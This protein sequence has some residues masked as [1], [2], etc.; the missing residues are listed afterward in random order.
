[1]P[2]C[3]PW[4]QPVN[5]RGMNALLG[6]RW[7]SWPRLLVIALTAGAL[8]FVFSR[9]ELGALRE[10]LART[11]PGWLLLAFTCYG[12]ALVFG[13]IRWHVTLHAIHCAVH[14]FAAI[15]LTFIGHFLVF[16]LAGAAAGDI[17]KTSLYARWFRFGV[18]ELASTAPIDRALGLFAALFVGLVALAIGFSSGGFQ[19][20]VTTGIRVS[21]VWIIL[22]ALALVAI[23]MALLR[24]KPKGDVWWARGWRTFQSGVRR[25]ASS[26]RH[27]LAGATSAVMAQLAMSTVLALNLCAVSS[28]PLPWLQLAWTFPTIMML[29]CVPLTVGGAGVR[30]LLAL[31]FLGFYGVPAGD[32]VG[33]AMLT[34]LC[35]V[36]W[37]LVGGAMFWTESQLQERL[38]T[39]AARVV[40]TVSVVIPTLNE[41]ESL[42]MTVAQLRVNEAIAEV[43]VVDGGSADRTPEIAEQL[44]CRVLNSAPGRGGQMRVGAAAATGDVILLLHADTWLE[45][46]GTRAML[47]CLRDRAV[48]AGG[49]WK[50]FRHSPWLLLG[51]KWKCAVRLLL[52]QR[53]AGDQGIF[54]RREILERIGGIPDVPLMEEF[55]LCRRLRREGRLA[56]ADA[57]AQTSARRFRAQGILRTYLRMWW[58]TFRYRL[59]TPPAELQKIYERS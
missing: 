35:K 52:S 54:V 14:A 32:C 4:R 46:G 10:S 30:E 40:S 27:A 42:P 59:G 3:T 41:A 20:I 22:A 1:M 16:L 56:L 37:S 48:V 8:F 43:I 2:A 9:I 36:A 24:W 23:T 33:A 38:S 26:P 25:L 31:T 51:S 18:P 21:G 15:R 34:F 58:V 12:L 29:S 13:S 6:K 39:N 17:V 50:E 44:G 7:Y 11:R 53:I 5:W 49:F 28:D 47:D 57:V 55:E 19:N 45:S